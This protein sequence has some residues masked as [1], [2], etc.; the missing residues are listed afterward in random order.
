MSAAEAASE[1]RYV[2]LPDGEAGYVGALPE[3]Y[4]EG[5][6]GE[7]TVAQLR[8]IV[9]AHG[10]TAARVR[11][12]SRGGDLLAA[13]ELG[14]FLRDRG[15]V[16]EVAA[17][18]GGWGRFRPGQCLS[19]CA[20][21]YLG[22][23]YRYLDPGSRMA[24]HRF[25]TPR[26]GTVAPPDEIE[27]EVQALVGALVAY[28]ARMGVDSEFFLRMSQRP[29]ADLEYLGR[30]ELARMGVVNDGRMPPSW[31]L[32]IRD[33]EVVLAGR[34]ERIANSAEITLHC[35]A[36]L[37]VR[38]QT[39]HF[40]PGWG[41]ALAPSGLHW[42]FGDERVP[43]DPR[44]FADAVSLREGEFRAA[45]GLDAARAARLAAARAVGLSVAAGGRRFDYEVAVEREADR[46]AIR[47][48]VEFCVASG[49]AGARPAGPG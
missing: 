1:L 33:G 49:G 18:D 26:A 10:L 2:P 20:V 4:V 6:I 35:N 16:T 42:A 23:R 45:V 25:S 43:V 9:D 12:D 37:E 29:H 14:H 5:P 36:P 28:L 27:Q 30:D 3:I 40:D 8:R 17:F 7:T 13:L 44:Q 15:F 31:G 11:F 24:V 19:A 46:D 47:R 32:E 21:A 38:L 41:A 48:F 34:Q 22:G 39:P